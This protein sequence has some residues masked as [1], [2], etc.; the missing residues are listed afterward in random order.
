MPS[1]YFFWVSVF[2]MMN[3]FFED[4]GMLLTKSSFK[5]VLLPSDMALMA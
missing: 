1:R 3:R 5:D 4:T 2:G